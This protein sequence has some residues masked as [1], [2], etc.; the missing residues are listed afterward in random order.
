MVSLTAVRAS[1]ACIPNTLP[2]GLVAV[3][4]GGT[5]GIGEYTLKEF[6]R[7]ARQPRIYNIGRSREASDRI[8]AECKKLNADAQ[9]TFIQADVSLIRRVDAVCEQVQAKE[10]T[11]NILFL[12]AGTLATGVSMYYVMTYV[13]GRRI[14]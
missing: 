13:F 4:V 10:K 5:S 14:A 3:F 8:A 2:S 9:Y 1:N 12:S 7:F 11:V 6:A